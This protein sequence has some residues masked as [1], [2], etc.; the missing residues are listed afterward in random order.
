MNVP[1]SKLL[2]YNLVDTEG[3]V[4]LNEM[5]GLIEDQ[6]EQAWLVVGPPDDG[7]Y[8][9]KL[10]DH[11]MLKDYRNVMVFDT[12]YQPWKREP[13]KGKIEVGDKFILTKDLGDG[14]FI[15]NLEEIDKKGGYVPEPLRTGTF[16][17][18][19][20][21]DFNKQYPNAI[22]SSNAGIRTVIEPIEIHDDY[23]IGYGLDEKGEKIKKKWNRKDLIETPVAFFRKDILSINNKKFKK[24][25]NYRKQA[26]KIAAD[27]LKKVQDEEDPYYKI[28]DGKQF[29]I[30]IFTNGGFGIMGY[31]KDRNYSRLIFNNATLVCQDLTKKMIS[32]INGLGYQTVGGDSVTGDTPL[33]LRK[34]GK[35]VIKTIDDICNLWHKTR[36]KEYGATDYEIWTE[37]GFTKIKKIIRHKTKKKIFRV[38]THTGC[39]DVTE[40]HSLLNEDKSK[41]KPSEVN[42][43]DYLLCSFPSKFPELENDLTAE[44][45]WVMGLFYADGTCGKYKYKSGTKYQW[46]ISN[47]NLELLKKA[48]VVLGDSFKILDTRKSSV[49][50]KLVPTGSIKKM[51]LKYDLLFYD[52]RRNKKVPDII[53]NGSFE[54]RQAFFDGYY[55]GDGNRAWRGIRCDNKGKIGAMGLYYL[56]RSLGYDVSINTRKDKPKIYRLNGTKNNLSN[57]ASIIKKIEEI[58]IID[59]YVYDLETENHHFH[60]GVGQ[61]I[62]HN[63]DSCFP[64]LHSNNL[65]DAIKETKWLASEVNKEISIYLDKVYNIQEH[66]MN[67]EVETISDKFIVK[68]AKNYVKR[69]LY[70][71]GVVLK[72]PQLE[73]KGIEMKKRNTSK[74][75]ADM[76]ETIVKI[77]LDSQT[78]KEDFQILMK[79]LDNNINK[80]PWDYVAP[81]GGIQNNMNEYD[82][83]NYNARGARNALKYF[84]VYYQAGDNPYIMPF[85]IYPKK[86]NGNFVSSYKQGESLVLSFDKEDIPKL[87]SLG[88][89]PD[90]E[91]LKRSQIKLKS[92]PFLA[93]FDTDFDKAKIKDKISD[94]M[95]L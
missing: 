26:Q 12:K 73:V 81:R 62:V 44:E 10:H 70:R 35:I 93:L 30:K 84:N 53:L 46:N 86:L 58:G 36:R 28:L 16:E 59:D 91:D 20:V 49:V 1:C 77:L 42:I 51:F 54:K 19:C 18:V 45:C 32:V 50:Y 66:T 25:L 72:E 69:N 5:W 52:K 6:F 85:K 74:V 4:L 48:K 95:E 38:L 17:W 90:W 60:A 79:V 7:I 31:P 68:A 78:I 87:K 75:A 40:D 11:D 64:I 29:R 27:Y 34:N 63:T 89:V 57:S 22:M 33:L 3:L 41:I 83:G 23:V 76:Q 24:W 43:G 39:V 71:D 14:V 67:V 21:I 65:E 80:L 8:A 13:I 47:T 9:S 56:M 88:F 61:L 37:R 82:E 55:A 92:D 94:D 15:N 2:D